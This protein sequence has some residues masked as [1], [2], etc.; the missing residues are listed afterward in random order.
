MHGLC[1]IHSS[2]NDSPNVSNQLKS[3]V[4][5]ISVSTTLIFVCLG[6]WFIAFDWLVAGE[7][8]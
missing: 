4:G 7:T 6:E 5:F 3:Y 1:N 8:E 2:N